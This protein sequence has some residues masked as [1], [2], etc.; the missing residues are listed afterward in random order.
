MKAKFSKKISSLLKLRIVPV[1]MALTLAF[2][3]AVVQPSSTAQADITDFIFDL[4]C[5]LLKSYADSSKRNLINNQNTMETSFELQLTALKTG[6]QLQ[7]AAVTAYR[8]LVESAF[9]ANVNAFANRPGIFI[10]NTDYRTQATA[11]YKAAILDALHTLETNI[12]T[13][14]ANYRENMMALAL[15]HQQA[16]RDLVDDQIST[17]NTALD[18]ATTNC[19]SKKVSQNLYDTISAANSKLLK[20]GWDQEV[21]DIKAAIKLV[22][23]RDAGFVREKGTYDAAAIKATADLAAAFVTR[24]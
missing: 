24:Q 12:D 11:D 3:T 6:W 20:F 16:L 13:I 10:K 17:I 4:K 5:S 2:T 7:D 21:K 23:E 9:K 22:N 1:T 19:T 14:R 18:H 15:A 8:G